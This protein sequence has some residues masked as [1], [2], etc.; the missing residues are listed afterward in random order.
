MKRVVGLAL[1]LIG[2]S[3]FVIFTGSLNAAQSDGA[4]IGIM[5]FSDRELSLIVL[6]LDLLFLGVVFAGIK[7]GRL[8]LATVA[9]IAMVAGAVVL[10]IG[11]WNHVE[12]PPLDKVGPPY[13]D[14]I[15]VSSELNI[16]VYVLAGLSL[17]LGALLGIIGKS[18]VKD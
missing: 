10:I 6:A 13:D 7:F 12:G 2:V 15:P 1:V 3:L 18:R 11:I 16:S 14:R 8:K 4:P 17:G 5:S 9:V